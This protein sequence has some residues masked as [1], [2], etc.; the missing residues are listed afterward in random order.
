MKSS[1]SPTVTR[2]I[3]VRFGPGGLPPFR[4]EFDEFEQIM[5][6]NVSAAI[7]KTTHPDTIMVG[8]MLEQVRGGIQRAVKLRQPMQHPSSII[9]G[10]WM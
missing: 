5:F 10:R 2:A 6:E 3:A 7:F 9:S 8:G 4:E 1:S